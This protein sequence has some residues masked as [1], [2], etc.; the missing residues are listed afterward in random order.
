MTSSKLKLRVVRLLL[1]PY[2]TLFVQGSRL[3][4]FFIQKGFCKEKVMIV[5]NWI[6]PDLSVKVKPVEPDQPQPLQ[7]LF[8]GQVTKVKGVFEL[9]EAVGNIEDRASVFLTIVGEGDAKEDCVNY[10]VAKGLS[11]VSIVPSVPHSVLMRNL[12]SYDVLV[13]PSHSEG[14]PNSVLEAMASGLAVIVTAV[15]EVQD[16]VVDNHNGFVVPVQSSRAIESSI[17]NYLHRRPLLIEHSKNAVITV[18]ER[19][20]WEM[21]CQRVCDRILR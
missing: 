21:N 9:I 12:G 2:A 20:G 7:L 17:R 19:H 13:L 6:P 1:R 14:F 3:E 5:P 16:S 11:N 8:T 15:G 18:R 4:S 10:C